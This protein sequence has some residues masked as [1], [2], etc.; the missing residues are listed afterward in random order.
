M[1]LTTCARK[2]SS[3]KII[4]PKLNSTSKTWNS[5]SKMLSPEIR[6]WKNL[7]RNLNE[8]S[9]IW[10]NKFKMRNSKIRGSKILFRNR[11]AV[12]RIYKANWRSGKKLSLANNNALR[13]C[14][15]TLMPPIKQFQTWKGNWN[16][17]LLAAGNSSKNINRSA[18]MPA[19][20]CRASSPA[21][22]LCRS[23]AAVHSPNR[24]K[25]FGTF[26]ANAL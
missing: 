9:K 1:R 22:I 8:A 23:F 7:C 25:K 21:I 5:K 13:L 12:Q 20:F 19:N 4:C 3:S 2:I 14:N 15:K 17:D 11:S 16:I 26:C 18:H 24:S 10:K 6:S